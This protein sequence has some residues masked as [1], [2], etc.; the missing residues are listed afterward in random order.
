MDVALLASMLCQTKQTAL[1]AQ[2]EV[3]SL[4]REM[5]RDIPEIPF[6]KHEEYFE[7]KNPP[8]HFDV[9]RSRFDPHFRKI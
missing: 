1:I 4:E 3:L 2:D 9:R 5:Q 6:D 7:E 8:F